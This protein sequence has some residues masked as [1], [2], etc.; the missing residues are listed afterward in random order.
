MFDAAAKI[1]MVVWFLD[2]K[3][4]KTENFEEFMRSLKT[5][6]KIRLLSILEQFLKNY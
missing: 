2:M 6:V 5:Y 4:F 1:L 3:F